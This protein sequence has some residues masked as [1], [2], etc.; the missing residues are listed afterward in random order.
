MNEKHS[1]DCHD[2]YVILKIETNEN[3]GAL[4]AIVGG[5]IT[6]H[7]LAVS[8]H[9]VISLQMVHG[10]FHSV[11]L[12]ATLHARTLPIL[13]LFLSLLLRRTILCKAIFQFSIL[14]FLFLLCIFPTAAVVAEGIVPFVV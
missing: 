7:P 5:D 4:A 12:I 13:S 6:H 14:R 11:R 8:L 10:I 2:L 3:E 1:S 9:I